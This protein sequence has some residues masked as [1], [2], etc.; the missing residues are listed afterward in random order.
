MNPDRTISQHLTRDNPTNTPPFRRV[1]HPEEALPSTFTREDLLASRFK[2]SRVLPYQQSSPSFIGNLS[3]AVFSGLLL[4]F[5]FPEWNLWTLGW[6][7]AAPLI[8][9]VVRDPRFWRSFVLG[10]LTGTIFYCGSSY[11]ITYSMHHYGGIS[12]WVCSLILVVLASCLGVFTGLFAAVLAFIVKRFSGWGI[13]AAPAVWAASEWARAEVTGVGWNA[14][15]Y[16][17]AFMPS[18]IQTSRIGGVYIVSALLASAGTVLVFAL[19]HLQLRRG[20]I[21]VTAAGVLVAATLA[22][23]QTRL[24]AASSEGSVV[25]AAVQPNVPVDGNWLDPE[26]TQEMIA[27]HIELSSRAIRE[28][29]ESA[30]A[31]GG[32]G[33]QTQHGVDLLI[34]PESPMNFEYDRDEQLQNQ[35]QEYTSRQRVALLINSWGFPDGSTDHEVL[36]NSAVLIGDS[37]RKIGEYDKIALVPFGEF[38]PAKS[39]IPF[40]DG[41]QALVGDIT[42]GS[43]PAVLEMPEA[44]IGTLI[45]FE[46]TRADIARQMRMWGIGSGSA[47]E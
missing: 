32:S 22:Y 5:A 11:W 9:A 47:V 28:A 21:V 25:V 3:L 14:L 44:K 38:I 39:W 43:T 17:Q 1:K 16:S 40:M 13:L 35:L 34:W 26:F 10:S 23:G 46:A 19:V 20:L 41:I 36:Y 24:G 7:A 8:L 18:V 15:G 37:G 33:D 6:V 45:C 4:V 42:P 29:S 27:R 12:W 31:N 2:V 30:S